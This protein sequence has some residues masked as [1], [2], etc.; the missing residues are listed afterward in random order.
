MINYDCNQLCNNI[1]YVVK[2]LH[3]CRAPQLLLFLFWHRIWHFKVEFSIFPV[4]FLVYF[5]VNCWN[6]IEFYIKFAWNF[7]NINTV[8]V[9][10]YICYICSCFIVL[11]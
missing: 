10:L 5:N 9:G 2:C 4:L 3:I 11:F 6:K 8:I 7:Q 1:N